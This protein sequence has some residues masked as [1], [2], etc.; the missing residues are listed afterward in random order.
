MVKTPRPMLVPHPLPANGLSQNQSG[1]TQPIGNQSKA[2]SIAGIC[3]LKLL[4]EPSSCGCGIS[5]SNSNNIPQPHQ[6]RQ[7]QQHHKHQQ[8]HHHAQTVSISFTTFP[9][10]SVARVLAS[11]VGMS[12]KWKQVLI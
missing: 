11:N 6:L 12:L 7:Q 2:L 4:P 5:I 3:Q 1:N 8:P 9:A 10:K